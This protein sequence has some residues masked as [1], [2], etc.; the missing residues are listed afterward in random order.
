MGL[1]IFITGSHLQAH[2]PQAV[3]ARGKH[4]LPR[5]RRKQL[6]HSGMQNNDTA[7]AI[8]YLS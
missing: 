4:S 1:I 6:L 3:G 7:Y 5:S 8:Q 2:S